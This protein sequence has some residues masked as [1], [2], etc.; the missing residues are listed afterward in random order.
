MPPTYYLARG[1]SDFKF[2]GTERPELAKA[3]LSKSE[4]IYYEARDGK[5]IPGLLTM[6]VG[7]K[8]GD[9]APPAIIHPHGGPWARDNASWDVSGWVPFLT[10]RGYAVLQP[11]YRGST[12]WG[13][14]IWLSGDAEWG[15]KMQDDKDDGAKWL[16]TNGYADAN[17]MAIFGYSYGGFAAFAAAVRPQ[18]P[19]KCAIAG[20]GVSD[21]NRL[22]RLWSGNPQQRAY[23]GKT[24]KGMN[25]LEFAKNAKIP[26]LIFHGDRDVR[27]PLFHAKDFYKKAK[28]NADIKLVIIKDQPHSLPWTPKMQRKSLQALETYL[29]NDCFN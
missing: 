29:E 18:S 6:P 12:G 17:K 15:Q 2:L 26:M 4:L 10:S 23:Q 5:Q 19:Y 27:V 16:V 24:V 1:G 14:D 20:A 13:R 21:L 3:N 9:K 8:K 22:G 28:K 11:Q 25:P 7:W